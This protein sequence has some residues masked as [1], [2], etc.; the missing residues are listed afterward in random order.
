MSTPRAAV[1][2]MYEHGHFQRVRSLARDLARGG[3]EPH[4]FTDRRFQRDVEEAG[5]VFE[6]LFADH[7]L[8]DADAES[9]P[10]PCR[11]VTFAGAYASEIAA[12]VERLAPSVV[13]YDTFA[14]VGRVVARLLGLP[15]VNVCANHNMDRPARWRASPSIRAPRSRPPATEPSRT[16]T[17][18]ASTTPRRSRTWT[19]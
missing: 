10:Q 12:R 16:C 2:A 6:D 3:I 1:F 18:S 13:V 19:G 4:V 14:V 11:N 8:E 15:Y 9:V 5:C 7:A 17:A